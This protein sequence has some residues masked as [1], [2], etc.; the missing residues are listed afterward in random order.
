MPVLRQ[1]AGVRCVLQPVRARS[2]NQPGAQPV[3]AWKKMK[4]DARALPPAASLRRPP[5]W[6]PAAG[7]VQLRQLK[8]RRAGPTTTR[9]LAGVTIDADVQYT[10]PYSLRALPV[11]AS[12]DVC[13]AHQRAIPFDSPHRVRDALRRCRWKHARWGLPCPSLLRSYAPCPPRRRASLSA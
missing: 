5:L 12:S 8:L 11:P 4:R 1:N 9:A 2:S 10:L 3:A 13:P 7:I 6:P